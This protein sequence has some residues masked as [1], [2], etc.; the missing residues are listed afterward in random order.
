MLDLWSFQHGN[1]FGRMVPHR[2]E[3]GPDTLIKHRSLLPSPGKW[4]PCRCIAGD[5]SAVPP[6]WITSVVFPLVRSVVST[7]VS[8]TASR[9]A[10]AVSLTCLYML[11]RRPFGCCPWNYWCMAVVNSTR[12]CTPHLYHTRRQRM[13][14]RSMAERLLQGMKYGV[15]KAS[16]LPE[17]V[18][19]REVAILAAAAASAIIRES[20]IYYM[21]TIGSDPC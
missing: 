19:F 21:H 17:S 7:V 11:S 15:E 2:C 14:W 18:R 12:S 13:H 20:S 6:L 4:Y 10:A 8:A 1:R 5:K 3:S 9:S 16:S